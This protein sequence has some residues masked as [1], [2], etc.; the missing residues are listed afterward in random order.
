MNN[1]FKKYNIKIGEQDK[2]KIYILGV[3]EIVELEV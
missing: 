3:E 1:I 2:V